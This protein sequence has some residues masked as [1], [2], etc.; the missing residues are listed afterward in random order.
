M[1]KPLKATT[2]VSAP[3][4]EGQ[5]ASAG[6]LNPLYF[7]LYALNYACAH[8]AWLN[9]AYPNYHRYHATGYLKKRKDGDGEVLITRI[10][11]D[12]TADPRLILSLDGAHWINRDRH[13]LKHYLGGS[14]GA[15]TFTPP[16]AYQRR[17]YCDLYRAMLEQAIAVYNHRMTT[18]T[19]GTAAK[20]MKAVRDRLI[21]LLKTTCMDSAEPYIRLPEVTFH[22][23]RLAAWEYQQGDDASWKGLMQYFRLF[24]VSPEKTPQEY[25]LNIQILP[26]FARAMGVQLGGKTHVTIG[27]HL[28]TTIRITP[29]GEH[30]LRLRYPRP[31]WSTVF[32]DGDIE[33]DWR[34]MVLHKG[35]HPRQGC[36]GKVSFIRLPIRVDL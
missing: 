31:G 28:G 26:T 2:G 23:L 14:Y 7:L 16:P 32:Y 33:A 4:P 21:T 6:A 36:V 9:D 1:N 11:H 18:V 27:A 34:R 8:H 22:L 3:R 13:V 20:T 35:R 10:P 29:S 25:C 12:Y 17:G 15:E 5:T 19:T 30:G 24:I